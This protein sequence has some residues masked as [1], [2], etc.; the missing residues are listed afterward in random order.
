M[1]YVFGKRDPA[2]GHGG[3]SIAV[4]EEKEAPVYP[5]VNSLND[6][7]LIKLEFDNR[8]YISV[9]VLGLKLLGMLDS[10]AQ[11]TVLGKDSLKVLKL[12]NLDIIPSSKKVK[13]QTADGSQHN[14]CG[15]AYIPFTFN[16]RTE[17]VQTYIVPSL[18]KQLSVVWT[19]GLLLI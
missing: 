8:P 11:V 15:L 5:D 7:L 9:E 3:S 13:I 12:I 17:I 19:F 10:G 4:N 2:I 1:S 18:S 14:V 6:E 16:D